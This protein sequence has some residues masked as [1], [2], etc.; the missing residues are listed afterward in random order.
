MKPHACNPLRRLGLWLL[1]CLIPLQGMA[2]AVVTTIGTQ[3]SHKVVVEEKL[4]LSDFRRGVSNLAPRAA[5]AH[6][7]L[8]LG[9]FHAADKPLRHFHPRS[10]T[11]VVRVDGG[12]FEGA[13]DGDDLS[14]SPAIGAFVAILPCAAAWPAPSSRSALAS[15]D[16]WRPRTHEPTPF[17]RPPR[18]A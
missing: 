14:I 18:A 5:Q 1:A 2:A 7:A 6:A 15:H 17:E 4:E 3:H 10:D 11:S 13:A 9:H 8:G 16:P 12:G